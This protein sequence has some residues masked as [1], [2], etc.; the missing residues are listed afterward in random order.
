MKK[1]RILVIEDNPEVRENLVEI[2]ELSNYEVDSAADGREGV[3]KALTN[4]PDLILC[5]VM[6]PNLDGFGVLHILSKKPQTADIPFIF[7]TAKTERSDIRKGMTLGAD[8]YITK[9]FDDVELLNAIETRLQKAERLK[10]SFDKT[11]KGLQAFIDEARGY[12]ALKA[13]SKDREVKEFRR[14]EIIYHEGDFPRYLYFLESGKVK[15]FKT[16]EDGKEL[17][18]RVIKPGEFFGFLAL[19]K[20]D[21]YPQSAAAIELSRVRLIPRD[22]FLKLLH[23]NKDVSAR[24]VKM[25]AD[26]VAEKEEQ[27]LQLAYNSI[28]RRVADALLDLDNQVREQGG[29][30]IVILRED[31]ANIVGTAKESVIRTLTE[32]KNDGYIKIV[33]GGGIV[34]LNRQKLE[35][36]PF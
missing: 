14:K 10:K 15:L 28:R 29:D 26:N 4:P 9:P 17:I 24:L 32:F 7:L 30:T 6:M 34:V 35:S 12:E 31:L 25:L 2:L 16:N 5:D 1:K 21:N 27:L 18:F 3:E 11:A 19:I 13:L 36:M 23:A 33:D 22:D 8:D 20:D